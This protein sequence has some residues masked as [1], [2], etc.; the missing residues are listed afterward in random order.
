MQ[1]PAVFC[2]FSVEKAVGLLWQQIQNQRSAVTPPHQAHFP[3]SCP[4]LLPGHLPADLELRPQTS[5]LRGAGIRL[6]TRIM[7]KAPYSIP[8]QE[9][10]P[11]IRLHSSPPPQTLPSEAAIYFPWNFH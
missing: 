6:G 9:R 4:S 10:G 7:S 5:L 11:G 1:S 8:E 3:S 2:I